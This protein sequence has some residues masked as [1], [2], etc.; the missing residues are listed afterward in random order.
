MLEEGKLVSRLD[1][2]R[3]DIYLVA[4]DQR[5]PT[6]DLLRLKRGLLL[7]VSTRG[8][9][10]AES[11]APQEGWLVRDERTTWKDWLARQQL[12]AAP[13]PVKEQG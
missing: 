1:R 7:P 5:R 12:S 9:W 3:G 8:L 2:S 11:F 13:Q 6:G 10:L 4:L